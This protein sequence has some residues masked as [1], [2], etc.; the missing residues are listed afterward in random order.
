MANFQPARMLPWFQFCRAAVAVLILLGA[1]SLPAQEPDTAA[2]AQAEPEAP[3][4]SQAEL[5][6]AAQAHAA[7][8]EANLATNLAEQAEEIISALGSLQPDQPAPGEDAAGATNAPPPD[9]QSYQP[10]SGRE[11]RARWLSRQRSNQLQRRLS[12]ASSQAD[13]R[14]LRGPPS[15]D[16]SAFRLVAERNIFDPNRSPVSHYQAAAPSQDPVYFGLVGTLS[17]EAGTFAF[18][19]GSGSQYQTTLKCGGTLAGYKV[20]AITP[21]SVKLDRGTN[22]LDLLIG[23]QLRLGDD[24][25]WSLTQGLASQATNESTPATATLAGSS[26]DTTPSAADSEILKRLRERRAKE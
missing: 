22:Q 8:I 19:S 26:P 10:P 9:S 18:F 21:D 1:W 17:Y 24:G 11:S 6:A 3:A 12:A 14:A 25:S 16:Y 23:M 15:L 5:E 4:Q 2:Q 20:V 13:A 7:E